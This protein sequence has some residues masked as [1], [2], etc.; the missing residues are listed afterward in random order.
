MILC[1]KCK[2]M[3]FLRAIFVANLLNTLDLHVSFKKL[4]LERCLTFYTTKM[5]RNIIE[6]HFNAIKYH[7]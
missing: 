7:D 6:I 3:K 2:K 5:F 4:K 1:S